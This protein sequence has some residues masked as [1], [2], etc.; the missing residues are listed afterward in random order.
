MRRCVCVCV[1]ACVCVHV[2]KWSGHWPANKFDS[3][4]SHFGVASLSK[5]LCLHCSSLPS[6]INGDLV[7]TREA[8]HPAVTSTGTW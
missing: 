7:L 5:K 3:H 6:C 2:A 1:R 4:S 8:A